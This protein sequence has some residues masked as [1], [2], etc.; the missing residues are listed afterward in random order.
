LDAIA[1]LKLYEELKTALAQKCE[2]IEADI[3]EG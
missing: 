2:Q 3:P 1:S